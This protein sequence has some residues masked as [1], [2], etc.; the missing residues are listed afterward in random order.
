MRWPSAIPKRARALFILRWMMLTLIG[1]LAYSLFRALWVI[2]ALGAPV[3]DWL[4]YVPVILL[5]TGLPFSW[6]RRGQVWPVGQGSRLT[7]TCLFAFALAGCNGFGQITT[8]EPD[9]AAPIPIS[10]WAFQ[11]FNRCRRRSCTI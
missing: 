5:L 4:W 8:L 10:F 11:P 7:F 6:A 9:L 3:Y 2:I 1:W